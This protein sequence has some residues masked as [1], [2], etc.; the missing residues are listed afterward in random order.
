MAMSDL[1][2]VHV[3]L[4]TDPNNTGK[5]IAGAIVL[6]AIIGIGGFGY[7]AGWFHGTHEAV[8][9]SSLPQASM[10]LNMPSKS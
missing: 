1:R 3:G 5:M 6:L 7:Q 10:P 4:K 9:D 8:P 2:P